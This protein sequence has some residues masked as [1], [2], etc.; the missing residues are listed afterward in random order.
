MAFNGRQRIRYADILG[1]PSQPGDFTPEQIAAL[2]ELAG[3]A[4]DGLLAKTAGAYAVREIQVPS[5]LLGITNPGGL[6]GNPTITLPERGANLVFAGPA[7]GLNAAPRFRSLV[8][9]DI[10]DLS[11][12]YQPR[13]AILDELAAGTV[14]PS[15][16]FVGTTLDAIQDIR[17]TA[18]PTFN[19]LTLTDELRAKTAIVGDDVSGIL[20]PGLDRGIT[21]QRNTN[22]G[23]LFV[24]A[25]GEAQAVM[26]T[27]PGTLAAPGQTVAGN[28]AT[29]FASTYTGAGWVYPGGLAFVATETQTPTNR[30]MYV[31]FLHTLTG[32]AAQREA[33]RF[34][35]LGNLLVGHQVDPS[36]P[37]GAGSISALQAVIGITNLW[38]GAVASF[39]ASTR[40]QIHARGTGQAA[41]SFDTFGALGGAL[42]LQD[43]GAAANNGGAVVFGA[44]QGTFAALKALINDGTT[45]TTGHLQVSTR[46]AVGHATLT[47]HSRFTQAGNLL[48]NTTSE[49][50]LPAGGG[51]LRVTNVI[52]GATMGLGVGYQAA[53]VLTLFREASNCY[54]NLTNASSGTSADSPA[55]L[56]YRRRG[57]AGAPAAV[58]ANDRLAQ[59]FAGGYNGAGDVTSGRLGFDADENYVAATAYGTRFVLESIL[60]GATARTERLRVSGAGNLLVGVTSDNAIT[61]PGIGVRRFL[62]VGAL[63]SFTPITDTMFQLLADDGVSTIFSV[64][65]Y[66][67]APAMFF[68]RANG[69]KAVPSALLSNDIIGAFSGRGYGATAYAAANRVAIQYR[70]GENWTDLA[71]GTRITMAT[72]PRGATAQAQTFEITGEGSILCGVLA[73]LATNATDGFL[74]VPTCAGTPTGVPTAVTGKAALIVN[75]T[76]NKLYFYSG[77]AWRDAG[78]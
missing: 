42:V 28:V 50:S 40:G 29:I 44:S 58:L 59:F 26:A 51:N 57:T 10:P 53:N 72:T 2:Q 24:A 54:L 77:G 73:A 7:S 64:D 49:A 70:A 33:G 34:S 74:Y 35:G 45:N 48:V 17:T 39:Y 61:A 41:T 55:V 30:G 71:Q 60:T 62:G 23:F 9:A 43:A 37:S 67:I 13:S 6:G 25:G 11:S 16:Q 78:P 8:I 69:T 46:R 47:E 36:I 5:A 18:D 75:T 21:V 4:G 22:A 1:R 32:A 66:G 38:S 52:E 63:T 14:G 19:G 76:N 65:A 56:M 3:L 68:R 27:S 31:R 12:L 20:G 15:L